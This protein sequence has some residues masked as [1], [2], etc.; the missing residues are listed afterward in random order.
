M[1]MLGMTAKVSA[2]T[3]AVSLLFNADKLLQFITAVGGK[4]N[5]PT[6]STISS[7]ATNYKGMMLGLEMKK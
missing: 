4:I 6:I 1:K 5:D 2:S 3:N 7:L